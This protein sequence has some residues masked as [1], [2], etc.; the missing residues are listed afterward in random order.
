MTRVSWNKLLHPIVYIFFEWECE[1]KYFEKV[2]LIYKNPHLKIKTINLERWWVVKNT[3][4][5][6]RK[7][8]ET[9]SKDKVHWFKIEQKAFVV[10]D[11]DI[12]NKSEIDNLYSEIDRRI[13]LIPSN[14]TFEYW[15]LSHFKK[16]SISS[17]KNKYLIEIKKFFTPQNDKFTWKR[18][19]D[20]L[21]EDNICLAIKNVE[22][23]N[24][25]FWKI[26]LKDKDPYSEV[27]KIFDLVNWLCKK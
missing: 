13:Y 5:L 21:N 11:I 9:L 25:S 15:I 24:T 10:F 27:I 3:R 23:I 22:D 4:K 2:K 16:Y 7:I 26:H 1:E 18:D 6:N 8:I 17:W 20:F 12:Y 14:W 19:F